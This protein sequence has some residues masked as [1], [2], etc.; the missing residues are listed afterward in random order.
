MTE[1][2]EEMFVAMDAMNAAAVW[3]FFRHV[4][5]VHMPHSLEVKLTSSQVT[6]SNPA[7]TVDGDSGVEQ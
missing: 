4:L 1:T 3:P 7:C 2:K 5:P 6:A